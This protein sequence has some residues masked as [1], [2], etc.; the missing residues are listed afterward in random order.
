MSDYIASFFGVAML[1]ESGFQFKLIKRLQHMFPDC[2]IIRTG[3]SDNQGVPDI[4]ILWGDRWA[5][6]ECKKSASSRIR[7]NQQYFVDMFNGMSFAAFI[8]PEIEEEVLYALQQSFD[9]NR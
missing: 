5:M 2:F 4:L 3:A 1:S 7:P 8:W 6:L 9:F